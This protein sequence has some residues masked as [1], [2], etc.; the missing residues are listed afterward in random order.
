MLQKGN[1]KERH[2]FLKAVTLIELMVAGIIVFFMLYGLFVVL[3]SGDSTWNLSMGL[4]ELQQN[5]RQAAEGMAREIRQTT[6]SSITV[7]DSGGRITFLH[8]NSSN[9]ISYYRDVVNRQI[10]REHPVGTT[11][12]LSNNA[13]ILD[14]C[15]LGGIDCYDCSSAHTV[16]I[17]TRARKSV[18]QRDITFPVVS[19]DFLV[20]KVRLRNE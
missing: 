13:D 19:S 11:I 3:Q 14:F 10:I 17:R 20:E 9:S 12:V 5:I 1:K 7:S 8:P 2:R 4:V 15:C 6:A 18:R 16:R